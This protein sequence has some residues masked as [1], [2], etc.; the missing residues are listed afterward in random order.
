[1]PELPE[2]ETTRRGIEPHLRGRRISAVT[3][4]EA[5]LRQPVPADLADRLDGTR[6]LAVERRAKYLRFVLD[7][8]GLLVHLGMSGSLRIV[9]SDEPA[10]RHDH[11][12]IHFGDRLL[13]YRDP[14]RFGSIQWFDP[15]HGEP[16]ALA[17]L[18]IEP[19]GPSFDGNW[20]F[21]ASRGVRTA[22]KL[23]IM[24]SHRLVGI[25]NI[26]ASEGLYR[27]GI[28]P[29]APAGRLGRPRCARLAGALREVLEDAVAAGGSTLRDFT[30]GDGRPG[31][32]QH[33]HQVYDRAG[34]PCP[35]C[36]SPLRRIVLGQRSTFFCP[37]CQRR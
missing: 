28:D 17:R 32:F 14:R 13:R 7:R 37:R 1:M 5:R 27:A 8:G 34:L 22:I 15:A 16:A 9:T 21:D 11:V 4:R 2:V 18:G 10:G 20:L 31:Y 26:Y 35:A 23:F 3:I 30:G 33:S 25:G 6:L 12:D 24:D 36:G 29:R 19:L